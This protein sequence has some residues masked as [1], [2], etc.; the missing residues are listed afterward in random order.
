MNRMR[1]GM[2]KMSLRKRVALRLRRIRMLIRR[3]RIKLTVM[4]TI[5]SGLK[6]HLRIRMKS[7]KKKRRI[8][9]F[10]RTN[11]LKKLQYSE[12]RVENRTLRK[13]KRLTTCNRISH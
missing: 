2:K 13:S 10:S 4:R 6:I 7:L 9:M 3:T 1:K 5:K 8:R 12:K 11:Q